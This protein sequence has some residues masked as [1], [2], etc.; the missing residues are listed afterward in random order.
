M[1]NAIMRN[2]NHPITNPIISIDTVS[3]TVRLLDDPRQK[4]N[5]LSAFFVGHRFVTFLHH[6][7][8]A[9]ASGP[10]LGMEMTCPA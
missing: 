4:F 1:K 6:H 7:L 3:H 5:E 2:E 9:E 8:T 10:R